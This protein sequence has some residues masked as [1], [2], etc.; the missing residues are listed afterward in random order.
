M[1]EA[2]TVLSTQRLD[3]QL[4]EHVYA[5]VASGQYLEPQHGSADPHDR[6]NRAF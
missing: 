1:I 3:Q 5:L 4:P 2:N 6:P